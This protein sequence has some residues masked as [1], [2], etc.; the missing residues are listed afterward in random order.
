MTTTTSP[1]NVRPGDE[2]KTTHSPSFIVHTVERCHC[3]NEHYPGD[4]VHYRMKPEDGPGLL[5]T[6]DYQVHVLNRTAEEVAARIEPTALWTYEKLRTLAGY[7]IHDRGT[8][9][10]EHGDTD[11]DLAD[12][13]FGNFTD[14]EAAE[15]TMEDIATVRGIVARAQ[16]VIDGVVI[17]ARVAD[18]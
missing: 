9:L 10:V 14:R 8:T 2:L 7:I 4:L 11:G 15:L 18:E 17:P 6:V 3:V 16:V 13:A 12:V 5:A 1:A